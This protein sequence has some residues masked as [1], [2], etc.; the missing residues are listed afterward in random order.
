MTAGAVVDAIRAV[1]VAKTGVFEPPVF[2]PFV[3]SR[4]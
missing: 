1:V 2:V 4:V 3:R